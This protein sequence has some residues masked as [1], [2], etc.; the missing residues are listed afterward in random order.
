MPNEPYKPDPVSGVSSLDDL[1]AYVTRELQKLGQTLGQPSDYPEQHTEPPHT[2]GTIAFADGKNWDPGEGRGLYAFYNNTW[3]PLFQPSEGGA[4]IPDPVDP[5]EPPTPEDAVF[6]HSF[7]TDVTEGGF[8][9]VQQKAAGRASLVNTARIGSKGVQLRTS[10]ADT[11]VAGSGNNERCDLRTSVENT[12]GFVGHEGYW[13][14]SFLLPDEY[15]IP[16]NSPPNHFSLGMQWHS[17]PTSGF[18]PMLG[19]YIM[20]YSPQGAHFTWQRKGGS[21]AKQRRTVLFGG[22]TPEKNVWHDCVAHIKWGTTH[23]NTGARTRLWIRKGNAAQYDLVND[24]TDA[25]MYPAFNQAYIKP[26]NY[27]SNIGAPSS[28]IY[29]RIAY[30]LVPYS[31]AMAPLEGVA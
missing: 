3:N 8:W 13:A 15:Q 22:A 29:D 31:V 9:Q 1:L 11:G 21:D 26:S 2:D 23:G 7:E 25:N 12:D 4:P 27:H 28:I 5:P 16:G 10:G 14:W 19:L 6:L 17:E 18:G 30:G 24:D 20:N